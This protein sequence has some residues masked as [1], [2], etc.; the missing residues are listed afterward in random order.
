MLCYQERSAAPAEMVWPLLAEP[1]QWSRWAPHI[2]GA[3]GLGHPEVQPSRRGFVMLGGAAPV[4]VRIT[5]KSPG[6]SW[7]WQ[8]GL[9]NMSHQVTPLKT[10]SELR[11]EIN[12]PRVIEAGLRITYGPLVQL[13]LRNC[14]RVAAA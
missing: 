7:D 4:L 10:G 3:R 11:I 6:R 8:V 12:A 1:A 14:A 2:R 9:V 5:A 13:L